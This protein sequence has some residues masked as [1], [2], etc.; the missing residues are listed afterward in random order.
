MNEKLFHKKGALAAARDNNPQKS[1]SG[2]QFYIVQGK[3]FNDN[4]L[5][6]VEL[7]SARRFSDEQK[8]VYKTIGGAPHLDGNYTV[9]G[10]VIKGLEV[11]DSIAKQPKDQND[12]PIKDIKMK[13]SAKKMKKKKISKLYGYK[14]E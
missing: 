6:M 5:N 11:I 4:E 1:S 10:E 7:R 2:C 12:R 14:Y 3:V 9:F 8:E 13:V